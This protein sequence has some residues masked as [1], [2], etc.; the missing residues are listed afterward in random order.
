M[1]QNGVGA[2]FFAKVAADIAHGGHAILTG[3]E[4]FDKASEGILRSL[5]HYYSLPQQSF[6]SFLE[7][8]HSTIQGKDWS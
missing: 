2:A 3:L 8:M 1:Y 4:T 7:L 5:N 6:G